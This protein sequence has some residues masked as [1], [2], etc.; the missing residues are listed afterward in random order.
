MGEVERPPLFFKRGF[1]LFTKLFPLANLLHA[2]L[3]VFYITSWKS[4][5]YV[6]LK[7]QEPTGSKAK[8]SNLCQF[9]WC[10]NPCRPSHFLLLLFHIKSVFEKV[11][12]GPSSS[13]PSLQASSPGG[14]VYSTDKGTAYWR[15]TLSH[16]WVPSNVHNVHL[17][18]SSRFFNAISFKLYVQQA[19]KGNVLYMF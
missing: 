2:I 3:E 14:Q 9:R 5:R 15:G 7:L 11:G 6:I 18:A 13:S 19:M 10:W 16:A 4:E 8:W 12:L 17:I 1:C